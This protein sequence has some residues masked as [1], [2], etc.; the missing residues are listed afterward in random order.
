MENFRC[1]GCLFCAEV[2]TDTVRC[3]NAD[4]ADDEGWVEIYQ[5]QGFLDIPHP[6]PKDKPCFWF[7]PKR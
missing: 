2:F 4:M 5:V 1:P 3:S 7:V 6:Q